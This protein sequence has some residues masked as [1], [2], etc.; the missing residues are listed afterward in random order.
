[1][2]STQWA[3]MF[4]ALLAVPLSALAQP[5]T[6]GADPAD[7]RAAVPPVVY[8]SAIAGAAPRAPDTA[9][10]DKVWRAA[11]DTVAGTQGHAGHDAAATPALQASA[12][13]QPPAD[14]SKH[15]RAKQ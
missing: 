12:P 4:G 9:T 6:P 5:T 3:A 11:N 7:P 8:T 1:M 14:H 10:P 2:T 15:G 13:A